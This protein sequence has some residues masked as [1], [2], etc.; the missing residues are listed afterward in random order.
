MTEMTERK[1]MRPTISTSGPFFMSNPFIQV[2]LQSIPRI[3]SRPFTL[4]Q[5]SWHHCSWTASW[6]ALHRA[7][8][9]DLSGKQINYKTN[10]LQDK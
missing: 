8:V 4:R 3:P 7:Q 6:N 2:I 10:K 9:K 5:C 1:L